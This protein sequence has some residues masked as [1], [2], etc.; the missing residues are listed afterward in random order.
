M[1]RVVRRRSPRCPASSPSCT[2]IARID[3]SSE[4]MTTADR[5]G[6]A[7]GPCGAPFLLERTALTIRVQTG[8]EEHCSY[9]IIPATRGASRSKPVARVVEELTR[10]EV[11]RLPRSHPDRRPPRRLW[12]RSRSSQRPCPIF[13]MPPSGAP[14]SCSSDSGSL[15]PMDV[16]ESLVELASTGR[17]APAFHLPLQ[18][19]SDAVLGRM[20]RP[21]T[22]DDYRRTVDRLRERLPHAALGSDIIVGFPGESDAE[23]DALCR[24]LESSP[25]TALHVFPY[26]DRPGTAASQHGDKDRRAGRSRARTGDLATSGRR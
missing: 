15:E 9:C 16:P 21:Y 13:S 17:V 18:H 22:L 14:A 24:Y 11:E 8:C 10:A 3:W 19:A 6:G 5:Y 20:R 12:A 4:G 7:D 25:L 26:S 23:F 1:P 2:T